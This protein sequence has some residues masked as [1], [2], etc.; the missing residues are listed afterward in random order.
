MGTEATKN[1]KKA[2]KEKL[3]VTA[4]EGGGREGSKVAAI[5]TPVAPVREARGGALAHR[6]TLVAGSA[7]DKASMTM[8]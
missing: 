2:K 1:V 3:I 7:A 4:Y 6:N 8:L 5:T